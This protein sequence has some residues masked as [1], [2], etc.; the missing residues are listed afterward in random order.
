MLN[1]IKIENLVCL[2]DPRKEKTAYCHNLYVV[3]ILSELF[4]CK[5]LPLCKLLFGVIEN[6]MNE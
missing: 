4:L 6:K 1:V 2:W 3:T 5:A